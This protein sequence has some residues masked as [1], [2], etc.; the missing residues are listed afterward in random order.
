MCLFFFKQKTAYEVRISDWSSD[1]CSSDLAS[2][3]TDG[4]PTTATIHADR[5]GPVY[6]RR[7][8]TQFAEH[9]GHGIYGG[10]WVGNDRSIPNTNGFRNDVVAALRNLSVPVTR[11]PGGRFAA[12]YHRRGGTGPKGKRP[13]KATTTGGGG[14]H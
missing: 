1:V 12:E 10:L 3:D 2:A 13:G 8:F 4:R 11:W 6:D 9:L 7:I 14:T 5:P